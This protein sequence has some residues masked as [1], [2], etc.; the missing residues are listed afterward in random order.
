MPVFLELK[1]MDWRPSR[2]EVVGSEEP[3]DALLGLSMQATGQSIQA[4]ITNRE[5]TGPLAD[6]G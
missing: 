5:L 6:F 1:E 4:W 3:P 2:R